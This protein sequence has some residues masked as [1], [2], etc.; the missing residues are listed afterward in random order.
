MKPRRTPSRP[1]RRA[2]SRVDVGERFQSNSLI[3]R[4]ADGDAHLPSRLTQ[5]PLRYST[6]RRLASATRP[7]CSGTFAAALLLCLPSEYLHCLAQSHLQDHRETVA[8]LST[9]PP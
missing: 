1:A 9:F 5:A 2:K 8:I 7:F 6:A 3:L 4:R